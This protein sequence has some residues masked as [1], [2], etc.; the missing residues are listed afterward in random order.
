[1]SELIFNEGAAPAT[2]ATNKVVQYAKADG[3]LYFKDDAGTETLAAAG[4]TFKTIT[5][6][7]GTSP[8]ADSSSDTLTLATDGNI[9]VTG[10]SAT[11][12]ITLS[13]G[14]VPITKGGTG[15]TTAT[16]AFNALDPLTT[17][18]DL[19]SNDGTNSTR[20]AVGTNGQVLTADSSA[21]SGVSWQT[22][23]S[24]GFSPATSIEIYDDFAS[25]TSDTD[26]IGSYS[27]RNYGAGT[28]NAFTR[29]TG[30]AGHP[31]IVRLTSGTVAT[32]RQCICLGDAGEH[33]A[34]LGSGEMVVE[35][36]VRLTATLVAFTSA[37]V[38]LGD[39]FAATTTH[40]NGVYF[41]VLGTDTNWH[42][43]STN[44]GTATRRD[45]GIAFSSGAW[46]R[47]RF[48]VNAGATSIQANVSGSDA[49]AAITTNIPTAAISP[50]AKD[51]GIAVGT[52]AQLD[53]DYFY[54][55]QTFTTSR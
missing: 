35:A 8:V 14:T 17:K 38:G 34:V 28:G 51:V 47:L 55:T 46:V 18:G 5:C 9:G 39:S 50:F 2:P 49:G 23:S 29:L 33:F 27:W 1:M 48:T 20:V 6:P 11:D 13:L 16:A 41:E 37:Q 32:G 7:S 44:G 15:Q 52:A 36:V 24:S 22:A 30:V 21:A 26:E 3:K 19:I 53:L 43:V 54:L 12:T 10:D 31:G 42:L 4:D 40:T 45:T 25:G